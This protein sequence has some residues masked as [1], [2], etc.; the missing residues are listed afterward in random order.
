MGARDRMPGEVLLDGERPLTIAQLASLLPR[1]AC[2]F[3]NDSGPTHLAAHLG[4]R[5]VALF[6]PGPSPAQ[7]GIVR[8]RFTAVVADP[9]SSLGATQALAALE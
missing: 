5:G 2:V 7:T 3:G 4:C 6:G 8:E 1:A 9:L